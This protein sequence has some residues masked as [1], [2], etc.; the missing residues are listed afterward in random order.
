MTEVLDD[1]ALRRSAA[2][3]SW[4]CPG[5]G[6]A[7]LG[8][9]TWALASYL[10]A[11]AAL[12]G[13]AW[14]IID[15]GAPA[16]WATVSL[17]GVSTLVWV[18]EQFA[19]KRVASGPPQPALLAGG[20]PIATAVIWVGAAL[21]LLLFF[22][23]YGVLQMAGSGMSPTLEIGERFF[24]AKRVR[25]E[26]LHRGS[27][28]IYRL[29]A[30]SAWGQPG[31]LTTS[32]ILAVPGDRLSERDGRYLVNGQPGGEVAV[33]GEHRAVVQVPA[34]PAT[35]TVPADCYFIVQ[36]SPGRSF[37]SQVLSWAE[38]GDV[39]STQCYYLSPSRGMF[40]L[41]E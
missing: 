31:W 13:I 30:R 38:A 40:K 32:R 9:G 22:P 8:R 16:L 17:V 34:A 19:V 28:I 33:L 23:R 2:L 21:L 39:E 12:G 14:L 29:S 1:R 36:D 24:Y 37:D 3:R 18:G 25:P 15:P 26:R 20:Y 10:I 7:L 41:V 4:L 6:F 35:L 11:V 27:V 5:A